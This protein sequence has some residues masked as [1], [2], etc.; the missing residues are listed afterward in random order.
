MFNARFFERFFTLVFLLAYAIICILLL[1]GCSCTQTYNAFNHTLFLK[2]E[3]KKDTN[4]KNFYS[5][6][7][8]DDTSFDE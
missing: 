1:A 6:N 7:T 8:C 2:A 3:I 5:D 4:E